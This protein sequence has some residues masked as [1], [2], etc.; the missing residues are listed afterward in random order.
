M[1][2]ISSFAPQ[3]KYF[4]MYDLSS[5]INKCSI[6]AERFWRS[7]NVCRRDLTRLSRFFHSACA[8]RMS[9]YAFILML[10]RL[11]VSVRRV[12]HRNAQAVTARPFIEINIPEAARR[13]YTELEGVSIQLV[14]G[15]YLAPTVENG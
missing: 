12:R 15:I 1:R 14:P 6:F 13:F 11:F 7:L 9:G 2:P 8:R 3:S 10:F 5:S 4:T